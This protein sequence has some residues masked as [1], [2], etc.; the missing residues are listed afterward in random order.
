MD[1][2]NYTQKLQDL[3]QTAQKLALRNSNQQ[4]TPEHLL[5]A[6]L[7]DQGGVAKMLLERV[8][9]DAGNVFLQAEAEISKLPQV[10]QGR[11]GDYQWTEIR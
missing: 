11:V 7:D 2:S 1:M 5:A 8:G 9:A 6:A 10:H 3:L 4:I